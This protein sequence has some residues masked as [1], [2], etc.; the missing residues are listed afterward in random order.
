[1]SI[2]PRAFETVMR[3][4]RLMGHPMT[5]GLDTSRQADVYVVTFKSGEETYHV[6]GASLD[7]AFLRLLEHI[8]TVPLSHRAHVKFEQIRKVFCEEAGL[9]F[10]EEPLHLPPRSQV[11][12]AK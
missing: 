5:L 9:V 3:E 6:N 12:S 10:V 4:S 11:R 1:M 2:N 8:R 7:A